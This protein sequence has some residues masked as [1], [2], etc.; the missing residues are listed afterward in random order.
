MDLDMLIR[1]EANCVHR[2]IAA[3]RTAENV[4][5]AAGQRRYLGDESLPILIAPAS[6]GRTLI[7][8]GEG[9][10]P[11]LAQDLACGVFRGDELVAVARTGGSGMFALRLD[12]GEYRVRFVNE[13]RDAD[14]EAILRRMGDRLANEQLRAA[15]RDIADPVSLPPSGSSTERRDIWAAEYEA[16]CFLSGHS[17]DD[18][19]APP[20]QE[21]DST[22]WDEHEIQLLYRA[23]HIPYGVVLI[24]IVERSGSHRTIGQKVIALPK[25]GS[26]R[27]AYRTGGIA[28]REVAGDAHDEDVFPRPTPATPEHFGVFL[29]HLSEIR[30]LLSD[31]SVAFDAELKKDVTAL[32]THLERLKTQQ[33]PL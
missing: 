29:Q 5:F 24:E 11:P 25:F 4:Y 10:V 31:P 16:C 28:F 8:L 7:A 32:Y 3:L 19:P 15:S 20:I 18:V 9:R 17:G 1:Q 27:G 21:L 12:P 14:D 13:V 26:D 22:K 23:Q 30:Q 2:Q 6:N 33:E